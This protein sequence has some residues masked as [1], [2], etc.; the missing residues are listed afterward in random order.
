MKQIHYATQDWHQV[1]SRLD[2]LTPGER[3]RFARFRFEKRRR[4]WL[5][6]RWT[7]KNA[8]LGITGWSRRDIA[9]IE[10]AAAPDGAPLPMLDGERCVAQLSLSHSNGRAFATVSQGT[11]AL[12]CD[13]ELVE[14]R[15]AAFI[16]TYFTPS[17][18]E[19]VARVDPRYRDL[20]VTMIWSAKES[21]LKA[22]RTGLQ[23]DTRSVEVIDDSDCSGAGWQ[24]ARTIDAT[25]GEFGCLWCRDEQSVLTVVTRAPVE[26]PKPIT[27]SDVRTDRSFRSSAAVSY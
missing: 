8:L 23:V 24:A 21:T 14:P 20:L 17:E 4:D 22:L 10:V 5:L 11:A 12:G 13:I 25:A 27:G 9:R 19:R 16:E 7:A 3:V 15:S 26:T 6:G 2:W 1:P 18:V